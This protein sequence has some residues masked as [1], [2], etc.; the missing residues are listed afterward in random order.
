[1]VGKVFLIT[2]DTPGDSQGIEITDLSATGKMWLEIETEIGRIRV[3]LNR[4]D[5]TALEVSTTALSGQ[6][7]LMIRPVAANLIEIRGVV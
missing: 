4:K 5:Q 1:M 6:N 2:V 3:G 7:Q